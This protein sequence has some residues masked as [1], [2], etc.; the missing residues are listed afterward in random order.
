MTSENRFTIKPQ[1]DYWAVVDNHNKDKVCII[2]GIHTR[3]E[4]IWLCDFMN[5]QE[6]IIQREM[7]EKINIQEKLSYMV[8]KYN[9][10]KRKNLDLQVKLSE[11]MK[12]ED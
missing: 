5:E 7:G 11:V 3:V 9:K 2:N 10:L 8:W 6:A 12:N 1:D 4:A